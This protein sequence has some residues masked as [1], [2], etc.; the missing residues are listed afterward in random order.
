MNPL[1][2]PVLEVE[3]RPTRSDPPEKWRYMRS[4]LLLRVAVGVVGV[5][6]PVVLIVLDTRLFRDLPDPRGSMSA[7][8]YSGGRDV[9]VAAL[10]LSAAFLLT[11][12][13]FEKNL[14]NVLSIAAGLAAFLVAFFPTGR[15]SDDIG[16]TPLQRTF[17][18]EGV[19]WVHYI[20]SGA[21][22]VSLGALSVTFGIRAGRRRRT[23]AMKCSPQFWRR[24][25]FACAAAILVAVAFIAF[26]KLVWAP[27]DYLLWG[28]WL[29]A[30][31]FGASWFMSGFELRVLRGES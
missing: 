6:L 30:W 15:P 18:E 25:H 1:F 23:P 17:S 9:F 7:Y 3:P 10:S 20:A 2:E 12:K 11:Y 22:I 21:F 24:F 19:E 29:A 8:Y 5:A 27:S 14:D 26:S 16:L 4:Y 31:A 13:T 28:E